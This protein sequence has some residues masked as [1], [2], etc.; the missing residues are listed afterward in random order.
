MRRLRLRNAPLSRMTFRLDP[1]MMFCVCEREALIEADL[2]QS[3]LKYCL[4]SFF[5]ETRS[6]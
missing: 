5:R 6:P 2:N 4:L 3:L 1:I